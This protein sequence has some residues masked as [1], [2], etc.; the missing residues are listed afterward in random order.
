MGS[1]FYYFAFRMSYLVV[2]TLILLLAGKIGKLRYDFRSYFRLA[3]H[4]FTLPLMIEVGL[5]LAGGLLSI[6]YWFL[7]LNVGFA[8]AVL[9]KIG[10]TSNVSEISQ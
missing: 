1:L 2:V 6:P 5:N 4:T 3:I 9:V 10:K 7:I 8:V